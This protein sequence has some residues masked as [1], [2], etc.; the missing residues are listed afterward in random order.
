MP[1]ERVELLQGTLDLIILRA[2]A[3]MGSQ[4]A[5]GLAAR[6]AQVSDHPLSLNQGTLYPA[7]IRLEHKGWIK[8]AWGKTETN[9]EAKFY[10]LT[11]A[12]E[13]AL[14]KE[15]ETTLAPLAAKAKADA[16]IAI[17]LGV[18]YLQSNN[19]ASAESWLRQAI[20]TRPG[21]IEAHFQLAEA[22]ERQAKRD[23]ALATLRKAFELDTTRIDVGLE[24][25]R[26]YEAA[27]RDADAGAM[28][29]RLLASKD[30][31][32]AQPPVART[33]RASA[34]ASLP[35]GARITR[36]P[37]SIRLASVSSV[38]VGTGSTRRSA[39]SS[40]TSDGDSVAAGT[41]AVTVLPMHSSRP[42]GSIAGTASLTSEP[43]RNGNS[44]SP[45]SC[46]S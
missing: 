6:L 19:P 24:L 45:S 32:I 35:D 12:G 23:E 9:R 17:R 16:K 11:K 39:Y 21:D 7:L 5:Y 22:L 14:Q 25:A 33:I 10:A 30:V 1:S 18:A 29:D 8:G 44:S 2:L 27:G 26:S 42:S 31:S 20:A 43:D 28:Y 34:T 36:H 37:S 40:A 46:R 4:H 38:A 41:D 3:T 13:K 15:A